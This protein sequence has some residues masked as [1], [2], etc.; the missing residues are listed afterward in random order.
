MHLKKAV[1]PDGDGHQKYGPVAI[2]GFI[3]CRLLNDVR[4]N[5]AAPRGQVAFRR[6]TFHDV[7]GLI[8]VPSLPR[9]YC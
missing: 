6:K 1:D 9:L 2:G 8:G 5:L 4:E 7:N 3:P